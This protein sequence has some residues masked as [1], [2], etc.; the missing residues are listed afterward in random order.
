MV[1]GHLRGMGLQRV[2]GH[3]HAEPIDRTAGACHQH[4]HQGSLRS[5]KVHSQRHAAHQGQKAHRD[6]ARAQAHHAPLAKG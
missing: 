5:L 6:E 1:F 2:V 3:V 4:H